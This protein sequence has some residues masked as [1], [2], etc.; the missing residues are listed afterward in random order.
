MQHSYPPES[1][2]LI[3]NHV[4][5]LPLRMEHCDALIQAVLDGELWKLWFTLVPS[6]DQM[7]SWI[8]TAL[9]E[10]EQKQ[11]L[12]FV[13]QLKVDR[14]IIGSTR[15][16]NIEKTDRRLEI[17]STWYSKKFQKTFV[18]T[19]CKL[20]LLEHAFENL[21]CIAVEFRTHRL[22]QNSRRAIERL[23]AVLDGI[24]RNHRTMPNGTL[25]DTAVYSIISNEWPAIKS[26]LLFKL[27]SSFQ[28]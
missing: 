21:N 13:V 2:S 12:P 18:N 28:A 1:V 19:E 22:N 8:E 10:Q 20:L 5:L 27:V 24:L 16:M 3:G 6:P 11:S 17:G 15:Y 23:G 4:E 9:R 25:R 14:K 7:K 26:H